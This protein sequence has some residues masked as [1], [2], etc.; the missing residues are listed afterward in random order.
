MTKRAHRVRLA[1]GAGLLGLLAFA[2][3]QHGPEPEAEPYGRAYARR[4][5]QVGDRLPDF[6]LP[7]TTGRPRSFADLKGPK[8]LVLVFNQSAD[9]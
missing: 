4:G 2:L 7:D 6:T 5:P 1:A 8:G 9:W 3:I